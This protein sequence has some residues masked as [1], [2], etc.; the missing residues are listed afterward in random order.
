MKKGF[1]LIELM[2][3]VAIIGILAAIAIPQFGKIRDRAAIKAALSNIQGLQKALETYMN[4]DSSGW[5]PADIT[6]LQA[7]FADTTAGTDYFKWSDLQANCKLVG[8]ERLGTSSDY[9]IAAQA[10]DRIGMYV[11]ITSSDKVG[12]TPVAT[13]DSGLT[14][15]AP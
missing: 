15:V 6:G 9:T 8:Y 12:S 11:Y 10:K 5:I 2:I 1:T 14:L 4:M 3:V 7:V 13:N